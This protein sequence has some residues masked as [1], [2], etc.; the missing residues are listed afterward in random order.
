[1]NRI[2]ASGWRPTDNS[3]QPSIG[4]QRIYTSKM[5][6]IIAISC[7]ALTACVVLGDDDDSSAQIISEMVTLRDSTDQFATHLKQFLDSEKIGV[8]TASR[9]RLRDVGAGLGEAEG[10]LSEQMG[11]LGAYLGLA[12]PPSAPGAFSLGINIG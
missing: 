2:K 11:R 5:K 6:L 4:P 10:K 3:V 9:D 7:L 8:T 1:M 12:P